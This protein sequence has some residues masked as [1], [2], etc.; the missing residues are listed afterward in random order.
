MCPQSPASLPTIVHRIQAKKNHRQL[1]MH[2]VLVKLWTQLLYLRLLTQFCF[3]SLGDTSSSDVSTS[4]WFYSMLV[5]SFCKTFFFL[6]YMMKESMEN[7]EIDE[8][9]YHGNYKATKKNDSNLQWKVACKIL[10]QTLSPT[11]FHQTF[12][13]V[14]LNH[15]NVPNHHHHHLLFLLLLQILVLGMTTKNLSPTEFL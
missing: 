13:F 11:Q 12:I 1:G 9:S 14:F 3:S 5:L 10:L 2:K 6:L 8:E 7:Q 4:A 15:K